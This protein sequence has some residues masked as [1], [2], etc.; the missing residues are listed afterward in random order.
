M[1]VLA[2]RIIEIPTVF[3]LLDL[4]EFLMDDAGALFVELVGAV[5]HQHFELLQIVDYF[6][7]VFLLA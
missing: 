6:D 3:E 5:E 7:E 1:I 2:K 4:R